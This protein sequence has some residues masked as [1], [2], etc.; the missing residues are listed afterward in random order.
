MSKKK[1]HPPKRILVIDDESDVREI[2]SE[3]IEDLGFDILG[4]ESGEEALEFMEQTPVDLVISDVKMAG[5]NGLDLARNIR[6]RFP[7]LPLALMS[8]FLNEEL[9][10]L[11]EDRIVDSLIAKPFQM[12][13]LRGVIQQ[14]AR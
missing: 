10:R 5:M 1:A 11:V 12:S 3:M 7:D 8:A 14:L 13:E 9:R 4:A 2:V 6:T